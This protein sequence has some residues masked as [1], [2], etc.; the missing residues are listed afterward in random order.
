M[1][2]KLGGSLQH[3]IIPRSQGSFGLDRAVVQRHGW[4]TAFQGDFGGCARIV[5]YM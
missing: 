3:V 1:G 5:I 4:V 2:P